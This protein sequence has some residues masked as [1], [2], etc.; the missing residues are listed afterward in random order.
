VASL[1]QPPPDCRIAP[2]SDERCFDAG[3]LAPFCIGRADAGVL[4]M[5]ELEGYVG[6]GGGF[7]QRIK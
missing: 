2:S 3:R 4:L 6:A 7:Y 5:L 1:F